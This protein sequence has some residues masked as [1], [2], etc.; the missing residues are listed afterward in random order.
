MFQKKKT[1]AI[2]WKLCAV[3]NKTPPEGGFYFEP[4]TVWRFKFELCMVQNKTPLEVGFYFEPHTV[5]RFN[6]ELCVVQNKTP[7]DVGFYF[8]PHT[9]RRPKSELCVVQNKTPRGGFILNH[10][11]G[12]RCETTVIPQQVSELASQAPRRGA[13]LDGSRAS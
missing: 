8:E 4:H 3:Q 11:G 5:R 2:F 9:V 12:F 1:L 6:F 7:L 13:G 10:F